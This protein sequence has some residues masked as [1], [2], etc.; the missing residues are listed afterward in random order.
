[1]IVLKWRGVTHLLKEENY[2]P[3]AFQGLRDTR[4]GAKSNIVFYLLEDVTL[5]AEQI[6]FL[7]KNETEARRIPL[8][9]P[10]S[11]VA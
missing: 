7:K 8:R 4:A 5:E 10:S 1:M 3:G 11:I 6:T 9:A 2:C